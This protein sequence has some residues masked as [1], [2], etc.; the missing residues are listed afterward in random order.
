MLKLTD[1]EKEKKRIW[2]LTERLFPIHRTLVN[3]GFE[4]SL[5]IISEYLDLNILSYPSGQK[6]YDWEIPKSWNV[7][8]AYIENSKGKRLIDFKDNNLHLAAY[9]IPYRGRVSHEELM[10]HIRY[11]DDQPNAIPYNYLYVNRDWIFNIRKEELSKF[12]D[13]S[14][15]VVIDVEEKD[16]YLRIGEK[17]LPGKSKDEILITSYLCHPSMANDNLSGVVAAVEIFKQLSKIKDR[18]Y[19]YRLLIQ[20]ETIGAVTYLSNNEEFLDNIIGGFSV[21]CCGDDG[22]ITYKKSYN[23]E[24]YL[25][26]IIEF[27][28]DQYKDNYRIKDYYPGGSDERQFNAPGV[29]LNFGAFTRSQAGEFIEYHTSNDTL[30]FIDADHLYDTVDSILNCLHLL[31]NNKVFTNNFKGEPCFSKHNISYPTQKDAV[32]KTSA[33][34]IKIVTSEIDGT[35]SLMD[36]SKKWKIPFDE[37]LETV[38]K[39]EKSGLIKI[40]ESKYN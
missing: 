10:S 7:K 31:E 13:E 19:S 25:D 15:K 27:G 16:D 4:K 32:N 36:I 21:Y 17:Y 22:P 28:L 24:S 1:K 40:N 2:E 20:P 11:L 23:E 3:E 14:Y 39:L 12:K 18:R 34:N 30:D 6:V 9:S 33:Y 38:G 8:E 29:R 5:D 37:V 26:E 35:N